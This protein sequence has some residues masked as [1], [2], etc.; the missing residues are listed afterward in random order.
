MK[1]WEDKDRIY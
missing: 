1:G